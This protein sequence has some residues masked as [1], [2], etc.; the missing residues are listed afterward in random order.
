ML[1][2]KPDPE[3]EPVLDE[4]L[5]VELLMLLP[6]L[7]NKLDPE[8]DPVLDELEIDFLA[9]LAVLFK[10]LDSPLAILLKEPVFKAI[11]F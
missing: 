1:D 6:I 3:L 2:S 5:L 7:D 10:L 4:L 8:L 11:S 9:E